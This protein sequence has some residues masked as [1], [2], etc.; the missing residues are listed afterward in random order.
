[1]VAQ[2]DGF[3]FIEFTTNDGDSLERQFAQ[4]GFERT[5][6]HAT[7]DIRAVTQGDAL[8]FINAEPNPF[9]A[10]HGESVRAIG[11]H[12]LDAAK[13]LEAPEAVEARSAGDDPFVVP[14]AAIRG[15]GDSLVY[16]IEETPARFFAE[17]A[18]TDS[19]R[20]AAIRRI[21]HTSNIVRPEN[22]DLW[23]DFYARNFGFYEKQYLDV[24][25]Q[26]SGQRARSMVGRCERVSIPI[27]ASAHTKEGVL[28]Q[29]DEFIQDYRGEGVQHIALL[30]D[31][32]FKTYDYLSAN[33]VE[34]MDAPPN[35]YYEALDERLPGHNVDIAEI[36]RRGI[37]V[38]GKEQGR[39]LLQIFTR[40]Q[41]GPIFF[42]I[43]DRRGEDGFGAGNFRALFEAQ[44]RDQMR[45]GSLM[46]NAQ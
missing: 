17:F 36:K 24:K 2:T 13:A 22:L 41:V 11:I 19:A 23:A 40:R 45:R 15:I 18:G 20:S 1:M 3:A 26:V 6:Q 44:E 38:D 7:L 31:D 16:L 21:D 32:I 34:F 8:F 5:W 10:A 12:V 42:E 14:A 29:N 33:G 37:L 28:N 25:G 46:E 43:I 30:T 9:L 27:A 35:A 4:F 39:I